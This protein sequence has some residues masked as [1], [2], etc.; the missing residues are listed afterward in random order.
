ML[1]PDLQFRLETNPTTRKRQIEL[2]SPNDSYF[3]TYPISEQMYRLLQ[4]I[5]QCQPKWSDYATAN[6]KE[7]LYELIYKGILYLTL[8]VP[9]SNR[10]QRLSDPPNMDMEGLKIKELQTKTTPTCMSSYLA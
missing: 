2:F 8:E 7:W 3:T 1:S 9:K 10:N 6:N 5:C 4:D